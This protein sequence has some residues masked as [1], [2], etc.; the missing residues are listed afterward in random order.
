MECN[1]LG[2]NKPNS[3]FRWRILGVMLLFN[4]F[5]INLHSSSTNEIKFSTSAMD[6]DCNFFDYVFCAQSLY[7]DNSNI[8]YPPGFDFVDTYCNGQFIN[9][10]GLERIFK[11]TPP[12]TGAYTFE[13]QDVLAG[14]DMDMFLMVNCNENDCIASS[15]GADGSV[16]DLFTIDL[17]AGQEYT[18]VVDGDGGSQ[19]NY[20][21]AID[22]PAGNLSCN[23]Y[24]PITCGQQIYVE[25]SDPI[26]IQGPAQDFLPV[27]TYCNG[28]FI[29]LTGFE[30]VFIFNAPITDTYT[31][32]VTG[33]P[34]GFDMDMFLLS[35]CNQNDCIA[36]SDNI[37]PTAPDII[38]VTLQEGEEY[39]LIVDGDFGSN[40]SYTLRVSC[41]NDLDN[42]GFIAGIDCDDSNPDI[43]P[44]A[45]EIPGNGIDE[46][47][48]GIDGTDNCICNF[49]GRFRAQIQATN[50]NSGQAWDNCAGSIWDGVVEWIYDEDTDQVRVYSYL[51]Q[52]TRF[53]DMSM[54][55]YYLCYNI[56]TQQNMPNGDLHIKINCQDFTIEGE[57]QWGESFTVSDITFN[58]PD[59]RFRWVNQFGEG[60][61]TSLT[62]FD[63]FPWICE[64]NTIVDN[65]E[66]GFEE[67]EDCN[68]NNPNVFPG[69]IE[70]CDGIDNNCDGL[71]DENVQ[72]IYYRDADEDGFGSSESFIACFQPSGFV[73]ISG[74]CN[75]NNPNIYPGA[76]EIC[77]NQDNNCNNQID[78]GVLFQT[79]Y[80]DLDGDGYGSTTAT[81]DCTVPFGYVLLSGDCNDNNPNINPAALEVCDQIDNN[82]NGNIDEGVGPEE[83]FQDLDGDGYGSSIS[84][85]DCIRPDGFVSLT[86]D[87][88]DNNPNI[89]PA[90]EELCDLIDNNCNGQIDEG[91]TLNVY[92]FDSDFDGYGGQQTITDCTLPP[93]YSTLPG[94]CDDFNPNVNPGT[95]ETC[96]GIDNN[97]NSQIDEGT[98]QISFYQDLDGDGFGSNIVIMDCVPPDGFVLLSGD[99]NDLNPAVSPNGIE[100]CDGA[101]NN[102]DGQ[103]DEGLLNEY[104][105]DL[106]A[107][108]FGSNISVISCNQPPGFST[109]P[110]DCDDTNPLIHPDADEL[111]DGIDNN[112]NNSIDEDAILNTFYQDFD[113][114][115][116]GGSII[117]ELCTAPPGFVETSGDC[118]DNNPE[119]NPAAAEICDLIDNDC[120][121]LIDEDGGTNVYYLDQ[122]GD[123]FGSDVS[124]QDCFAP[125]GYVDI[126]GDCDDSNSLI[127][128]DA[129]E[130]PNNGVDEDCNGEDEIVDQDGDGF[131]SNF[132]CDDT[133]PEINPDAIEI[134]N[135][136]IDEDCDGIIEI[137]DGDGD[138]FHSDEDCDDNNF[139]I[140]PGAAED[141]DGIDNNCNG[142]IDEGLPTTIFYLDIDEDGYGGEEF[143]ETCGQPLGFIDEGGDCDDENP[144][145]YPGAP[146]IANNGIDEDCDGEDL[147][148]STKELESISV[149]LYPN[150]THQLL[151]IQIQENI[152]GAKV[153]V[154]NINGQYL[155]DTEFNSTLEV[156]ELLPGIYLLRISKDANLL[157]LG[158]FVKI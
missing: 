44:D 4:A 12:T 115:G 114:D 120:D 3:K 31:F 125:D 147:L 52:N 72:N 95:L 126:N 153:Q 87:C 100:V 143:I 110:G 64:N 101:D 97:C 124:V 94:D 63:G 138:G 62:R 102:C 86:G 149:T 113:G 96:D 42:D 141:C 36:T 123:G 30:R 83:Y 106:D 17:T 26:D 119:I 37:S 16:P 108:G 122:D 61:I 78:E 46:N 128:P 45:I 71:V 55:G 145:I 131:N 156:D 24:E 14:Q 54:G 92:Y 136:D 88:N 139:N 1:I 2:I 118:D 132:D 60:A 157:W 91:L 74:D 70:I 40:T 140:N 43:N 66:D 133:N 20:V 57:S 47:C 41:P 121:Q 68:D 129:Y 85:V 8:N 127:N 7:V 77:D 21:L 9:L 10:T 67:A 79:Y 151:N 134:P 35:S 18:L 130:I 109:Q 22:C 98:T 23:F 148:S 50:Q 49:T 112:C 11:F 81:Q 73:E 32:S 76:P 80:Q 146:E 27:D 103:I 56:N 135:N 82:C 158:K 51:D 105:Q 39:Y 142:E 155:I 144:E 19:S 99:C 107:D 5:Q 93:G 15:D 90:S 116:F 48:D 111:C 69:A 28:Q 75:D 53:E 65:D 150:P 117:V 84:V 33:V 89:S 29:N 152:A 154:L 58:G 59:L 137:I 25:N 104:F 38:T 34:T 6:W 13:L